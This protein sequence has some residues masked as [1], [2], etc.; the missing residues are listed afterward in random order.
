MPGTTTMNSTLAKFSLATTIVV[1]SISSAAAQTAISI[2]PNKDTTLYESASGSLAG[3]GSSY[4][5]VGRVGGGGNFER[6]RAVMR[7]DI[8]GSIPAGSRILSAQLDLWVDQSSAFLPIATNVHR[9][10]QD[11]SEGTVVAPG[12]GGQGGTSAAGETTWIHTNFPSQLWANAGGDFAATPS[13]TFDLPGIGAVV[14]PSSDGLVADVQSMLDNPANNF[15]W[16]L[17]TN[18]ILT[19][20][21]RKINSRNAAALQPKLNIIYLAPGQTGTWG[22]G[23]S[24]GTGTFQLS[25]SGTAAGGS[26]VPFTFS[27][28]PSPSVGVN[29][30]SLALNAA[31]TPLLPNSFAYLPLSGPIV[32]GDTVLISGGVGASSFTV[33]VGFPGFLIVVQT[34]VLDTTPL[35]VSLS[36]AGLMLTQ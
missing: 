3:G 25:I 34:A 1:A 32:G 22:T 8:A 5:F 14:T 27:N 30:Y 21:A 33:P 26:T 18:E 23:W 19:S 9:V 13:L 4:V 7:W 17:K 16:L 24:V 6:R 31:G 29:F 35:G 10:L 2:V 11:W 15:G 36:N 12:G 28:A 20:N